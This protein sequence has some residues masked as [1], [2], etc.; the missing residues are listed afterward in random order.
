MSVNS[1][2]MGLGAA[3]PASSSRCPV[4]KYGLLAPLL[5][6]TRNREQHGIKVTIV[7]AH[8]V[9]RDKAMACYDPAVNNLG[10]SVSV[11]IPSA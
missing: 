9:R 6:P 3:W 11:T 8:P 1:H 4:G 5:I 7:P 10:E 2:P